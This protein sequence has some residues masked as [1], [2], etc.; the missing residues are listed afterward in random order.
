MILFELICDQGHRF[1]G[2]F[3][4][5][6]DFDEQQTG[7][8]IDCPFCGS[9]DV[10]KAVS[11]PNVGRKSNQSSSIRPA[12]SAQE[13][14]AMS[15]DLGKESVEELKRAAHKLR[16]AV[17][18]HCDYVGDEFPEEA[19][20]IHYGETEPRGIY[21]EASADESRELIDEGIDVIPLPMPGKPGRTD[22]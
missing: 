19:R 5:G 21:G 1:E 13:Q 9:A 11:A 3:R 10:E 17:E 16:A 8:V 2:W 7:K 4:S 14:S 20:K 15:P 12:S 18:K 22:A 6:E